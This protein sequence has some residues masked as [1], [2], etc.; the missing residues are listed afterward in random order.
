MC[1]I[2]TAIFG[3][4]LVQGLLC[5]LAIWAGA[6]FWL[7]RR[8]SRPMGQYAKEKGARDGVDIL[9]DQGGL[10]M[11][12]VQYFCPRPFCTTM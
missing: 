3:L 4:T 5:Y 2:F 8:L 10:A 7:W 1:N 11:S 12:V 9:T 6:A